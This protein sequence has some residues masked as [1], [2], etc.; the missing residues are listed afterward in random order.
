MNRRR[1]SSQLLRAAL[2]VVSICAISC[3]ETA[4]PD[5]DI[6]ELA[7]LPL[8]PKPIAGCESEK[9]E[10]CDIRRSR[11]QKQVYSLVACLRGH[12][13]DT[14][15]AIRVISEDEYRAERELDWADYEVPSPN[16]FE[17]ALGLLGLVQKDALSQGSS[18][19][20]DV[21]LVAGYYSR[22]TTSVTVIDH[23]REFDGF[24]AVPLLAHEFVHAQ[25]DQT[26]NLQSLDD[27]FG[28]TGDNRLALRSLVEG[29]AAL[30][31]ALV[32]AALGGLEVADLDLKRAFSQHAELLTDWLLV[33]PSPYAVRWAGF[34]Y[35]VGARYAYLAWSDFNPERLQAQFADPP[36]STQRLLASQDALAP[37]VGVT[38]GTLA[39]V[40]PE[41]SMFETDTVLGALGILMF[42]GHAPSEDA[43]SSLKPEVRARMF[44]LALAW[45]DDHLWVYSSAGA[46]GVI[47]TITF[48]SKQFAAD[49]AS[50]AQAPSLGL[51]A[52][53]VS[54]SET[55]VTL[56]A[57]TNLS[58][59]EQLVTAADQ[60]TQAE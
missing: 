24:N 52:L 25:Q 1:V 40:L 33:Q 48:S 47:W 58:L 49:F 12:S 11:C 13:S 9:Y 29:E 43:L 37:E 46:S 41:P 2:V 50:A 30:Y 53:R 16:H 3:G 55:R 36:Q 45:R 14:P 10:Y 27:A 38:I 31:E 32:T 56:V 15:P 21:K 51:D 28:S 6:P 22:L 8:P 57:A 35:G 18:I 26:L 4:D 19:D 39:P 5:S 34:P 42:L 59:T 23:G 60:L 17:N 54:V 7:P 20:D 44:K